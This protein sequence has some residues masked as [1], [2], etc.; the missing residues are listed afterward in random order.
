MSSKKEIE[1][2]IQARKEVLKAQE[3]AISNGRSYIYE[4]EFGR[5]GLCGK[6]GDISSW[7]SECYDGC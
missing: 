1:D 4:S 2:L 7:R 5:C 3:E 6:Y